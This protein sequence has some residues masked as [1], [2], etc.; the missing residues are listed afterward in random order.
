MNLK[1]LD[2]PFILLR[3]FLQELVLLVT[4]KRYLLFV[5]ILV[6]I[7]ESLVII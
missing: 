4:N 7:I 5:N 1:V 6:I 3:L 2:F